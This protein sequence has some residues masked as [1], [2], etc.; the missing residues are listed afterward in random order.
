MNTSSLA[1]CLLRDISQGK[2]RESE[3][4]LSPLCYCI[5]RYDNHSAKN[6]APDIHH[7]ARFISSSHAH[8]RPSSRKPDRHQNAASITSTSASISFDQIT[9]SDQF[10]LFLIFASALPVARGPTTLTPQRE[11]RFS[12]KCYEIQSRLT[13]LRLR[14]TI[15]HLCFE[16]Q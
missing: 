6:K 2:N 1:L 11:S 4:D 8:T 3:K 14:S 13:A 9:L 10:S 12:T 5:G 15:I 16:G 7:T